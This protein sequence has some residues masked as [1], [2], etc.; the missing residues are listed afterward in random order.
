MRS[1]GNRPNTGNTSRAAACLSKHYG[2]A[3]VNNFSLRE[4][5]IMRSQF[6]MTPKQVSQLQRT[7]KRDRS[8][9]RHNSL[10]TKGFNQEDNKAKISNYDRERFAEAKQ[11]TN[12]RKQFIHHLSQSKTRPLA[13]P[14]DTRRIMSVENFI[15]PR[16]RPE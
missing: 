4:R 7:L 15:S 16:A 12:L 14:N 2:L 9:N 8:P 5:V 6:T 11:S 1:T 13:G 3:K 10:I